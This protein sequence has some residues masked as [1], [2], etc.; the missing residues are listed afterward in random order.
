MLVGVRETID[1][2]DEQAHCV[3]DG[4]LVLAVEALP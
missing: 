3:A 4:E 2:L 1:D